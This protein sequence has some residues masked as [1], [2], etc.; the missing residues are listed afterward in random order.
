MKRHNT[1]TTKSFAS[2]V[3]QAASEGYILLPQQYHGGGKGRTSAAPTSEE[4]LNATLASA[5]GANPMWAGN[6]HPTDIKPSPGST[7]SKGS[8]PNGVGTDGLS[9]MNWGIDNKYP[10]TI[11][12]LTS[13]LPYPVTAVKFNVDVAA[14]MGFC[15]KYRYSA[16]SNGALV[17]K[18]IDY[19]AAGALLED[20][21]IQARRELMKFYQDYAGLN[22]SNGQTDPSSPAPDGFPVGTTQPTQPIKPI[23]DLYTQLE[24]SLLARIERVEEDLAKWQA[25]QAAVSTFTSKNNL[26]LLALH[27]FNDMVYFDI[28]F[29]ELELSS[30]KSEQPDNAQWH[31]TITGISYREAHTCRLEEMDSKGI[32]NYVYHSNR[33][34]DQASG[35]QDLKE[36]DIIA[37]P[38]LDPEH[39]AASL[40]KKVRNFRT[41][42]PKGSPDGRPTRFICPSYYP[43]VGKP[44]YP[45]PSWHSIFGGDIF[46]YLATIVS[47]RAQRRKNK[48]ILG[49][50]IYVH[51]DYI[52]KL[53]QQKQQELN[54][55]NPNRKGASLTQREQ[56][57]LVDEMWKTINTFI[58]ERDNAGKP[59]LAFTFTGNDGKDHDAYR[60]VE[61]PNATAK[62]AQAQKTELEEI[63][64]IIFFALQCHPELIGAVPGRTGAGGGT[65]Q[66]E[67]YLLKQLQIAPTQ[68]LVLRVLD[69]I[70]AFNQ[71]DTHLVWTVRQQ[72][73][74]TLDNSKTGLTES[75]TK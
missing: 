33:W 73:L 20:Q 62:D 59:L 13:L 12:T 52:N 21:L 27:L 35:A 25:T 53:I 60:I 70:T 22:G 2:K 30:E 32:I 71:W 49:Y 15:P 48:N 37:I 19:D 55:K 40:D 36:D 65:Y 61:V 64:A 29:P 56:Q 57:Q 8:T 5:F 72:V 18:E 10:N 58:A 23:T 51:Q 45:Q 74:T 1:N 11:A 42:N 41:Q 7:V 16:I 26:P 46:A 31:P 69:T 68:Q 54:L 9:Y 14:G 4:I 38:A 17:T 75:Q 6:T 28:C 67:L 47:D 24:Q 39:P 50:I 66:R 34:L 3:A 43:T 44:Y 63:S